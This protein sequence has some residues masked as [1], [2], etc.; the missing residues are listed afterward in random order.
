MPLYELKGVKPRLGRDVFVADGAR[1]IGDVHIGDQSSVWFGAV[2][3]GDYMPIRIGARTN[4]QDNAVLH[5]TS[6]LA[7]TTL[8][9]DVTIGHA[10]IVHGC[11]IGNRCLVGMGSIVLDGAVIGDDSFVAAGTLVTPGT[12]VPPKSFVLGRPAKV[13]RAV[14][15]R[16]LASMREAAARYVQYAGEFREAC[17]LSAPS[18]KEPNA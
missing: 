1:I 16:D 13:A 12:I 17:R 7:A 2:L 15:E 8:G 3:R 18:P 5:I 9:D 10:A 11:T 14:S 4:V 6:E